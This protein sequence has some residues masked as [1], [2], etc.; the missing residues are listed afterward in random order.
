MEKR[1]SETIQSARELPAEQRK[2]LA[3]KIIRNDRPVTQVSKDENVSRKF[4]YKQQEIAL[5]GVDQ[6][7][8]KTEPKDIVLCNIPVTKDWL[9]QSVLALILH[10]RSSFRG[11]T[12]VFS[13]LFGRSISIGTIHNTVYDAIL[14]ADAI[15]AAQ[16]LSNVK[17]GAHDEVFHGAKPVLTGVDIESLYCYLLSEEDQRDADTWAIHLWDLEKQGFSPDYIVAD[18]ASGLRDG[19]TTALPDIPCHGDV[20]HIIRPLQELRQYLANRAKSR[21]TELDKIEAKMEKAKKKKNGRKLSTKLSRAQKEEEKF[22]ELS[23]NINILVSWMEHDILT[24]AGDEPETRRELYDFIVDEIKNLE[25]THPH[26]IKDVRRLLENQR[27]TVL[28]FVD[29][30]DQ[31]FKYLSERHDVSSKLLWEL[32]KLQRYSQERHVYYEKAKPLRRILKYKFYAVQEDVLEAMSK[33]PKASSADE[34]LH[35]RLRP[36]FFLRKQIGH[37][38]LKL[39]RFYLNHTP[40]LRSARPERVGKTAAEVLTGKPHPHWLEMLGY[41]RFQPVIA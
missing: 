15:N 24:L 36:Y 29:V 40:F 16:D 41:Q 12:K 1:T 13:D 32:C 2:Q 19:Q 11:V 23:N 5:S 34:N 18:F 22:R 30:L 35:S 38:Y 31:K 10:C 9:R 21:E 3:L 25:S 26:R 8:E 4:L 20:F 39:L 7:F 6:A 33:T 28:A 17:H 14:K 37:D 27:D